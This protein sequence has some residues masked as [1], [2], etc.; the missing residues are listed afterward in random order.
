MIECASEILGEIVD[1]LRKR[2]RTG[3]PISELAADLT[4]R[5][6][7]AHALR[8]HLCAAFALER[9]PHPLMLPRDE[10]GATLPEGWR[11]WY[12]PEVDKQRPRWENA[13]PY[14]DLL[15][16]RDHHSFRAVAHE[17]GYLIVVAAAN[18]A[19]RAYV[20]REGFRPCPEW[21][22]GAARRTA[23]HAG[24]LAADPEDAGLQAMLTGRGQSH[25]EYCQEL[26]QAGLRVMADEGH[27][28]LDDEGAAFFPGYQLLGV[29]DASGQSAW[30]VRESCR[31]RA[32][33]NRR[34]GLELVQHG[35]HDAWDVRASLDPGSS[36]RAPL[37]PA[38]LFHRDANVTVC[39]DAVS[40]KRKLEYRGVHWEALYGREPT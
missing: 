8:D 24:L 19:A 35:P 27:V 20:G 36:L 2:R 30:S 14:P 7:R 5:G 34:M 40:L 29:Y 32:A 4:A 1:E 31:L 37:A 13:G 3:A 15:R 6:L 9:A 10:A 11:E 39:V 17:S 23:P 33:L 22:S 38:L 18:P 21:L 26:A 28:I 12:D 16:R 25:T